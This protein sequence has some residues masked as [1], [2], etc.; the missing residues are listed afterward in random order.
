MSETTSTTRLAIEKIDKELESFKGDPKAAA[1]KTHVADVLKSFCE[2]EEEFAQAII[3]SEITLSD[4]C[5]EI[6]K[7]VISSISDLEVYS[8]A[9]KCYFS[10]ATISFSMAINL[11]G[12]NGAEPKP[13]TVTHTD[14]MPEPAS[15]PK[16]KQA[17]TMSLDDLLDF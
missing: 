9:V 17:L 2:Q 10:T 4:C 7:G 11:S 13:I 3:Q 6:L 5:K 12:D 8:K 15:E 16:K 1:V 14:A